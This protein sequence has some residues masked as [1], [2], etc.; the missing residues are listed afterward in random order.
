MA[1]N[2][3]IGIT[4]KNFSLDGDGT[5]NFFGVRGRVCSSDSWIVRGIQIAPDSVMELIVSCLEA[6]EQAGEFQRVKEIQLASPQAVVLFL[7]GVIKRENIQQATDGA[8]YV[9][10]PEV[11]IPYKGSKCLNVRVLESSVYTVAT[12]DELGTVL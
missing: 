2:E 8:G 7:E 9:M 12:A 5:I 6:D 4:G 11:N 3:S 1:T 10:I